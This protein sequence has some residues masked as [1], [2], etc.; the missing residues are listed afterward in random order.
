MRGIVHVRQMLKVEVG[1][2][3][4]GGQVGVAEQ[5]LH[6]A[7]IA[8]RLQHVG[9]EGVA[10]L[11]RVDMAVD[12]LFHTPFGEALLHVARRNAPPLI[13]QEHRVIFR[14]EQIAHRQPVFQR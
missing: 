8:A 4:R 10:Q 6:R 2:N 7:Q 1:I 14:P 13:G 5:L 9:S 12:A 11:V 3:L